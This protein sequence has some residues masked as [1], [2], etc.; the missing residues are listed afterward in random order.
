MLNRL[1][2]H[3]QFV[4]TLT[5]NFTHLGVRQ[6]VWLLFFQVRDCPKPSCS[7]NFEYPIDVEKLHETP[8]RVYKV[9][10]KVTHLRW[11]RFAR[12]SVTEWKQRDLHDTLAPLEVMD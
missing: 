3:S 8:Q 11:L 7:L 9:L 6:L 2:D 10:V 5:K 1:N 12:H 4:N